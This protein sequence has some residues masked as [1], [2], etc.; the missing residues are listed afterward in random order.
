MQ[1]DNLCLTSKVFILVVGLMLAPTIA[2]AAAQPSAQTSNDGTATIPWK[3]EYIA[4]NKFL[5]INTS[6]TVQASYPIIKGQGWVVTGLADGR[7]EIQLTSQNQ[8]L[9]ITT[10]DVQHYPLRS[11]C[12]LFVLGALM[13][14]YLVVSL[15]KQEGSVVQDD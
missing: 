14:I 12:T 7:Y 10:L 4:Y 15:V 2:Q 8:S 6:G 3:S 1:S 9:P 11:A 13:F 5:V